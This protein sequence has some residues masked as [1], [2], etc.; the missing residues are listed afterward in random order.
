MNENKY[1]NSITKIVPEHC[2]QTNGSKPIRVFCSDLNYYVCKYNKGLGFPW[3]LFNEYIA[4]SFL[5]IYQLPVPDFAFVKIKEEH[6]ID[7]EYP[8]HYFNQLCFGSKY[9]GNFTEVDKLFLE[10]PII[11]KDNETGRNSY[12]KIALFDIWMCNEDRHFENFNL[13][14]N[15]KEN[16]FVPIDHVFCFNSNNLDKEPYLISENE[17]ILSNPFLNRFFDRNLQTISDNIR[18]GII[19]EFKLNVSRCYEELNNILAKT[20]ITWE[21]DTGFLETRLHFLFTDEW[22]ETCINHFTKIYFSNLKTQ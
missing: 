17:S 8:Y 15:L 7:I 1:L 10:T 14:Y 22:I 11:R 20:P 19:N 4:A 3:G 12:L 13:L 21:P 6:V 16:T 18:L 5:K 2:Y 9:M